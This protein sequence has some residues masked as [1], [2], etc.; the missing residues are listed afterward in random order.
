[1]KIEK[2]TIDRLAH[3]ARLNL[4]EEQTTK[5][6]N[7]LKVIL[8]WIEK[9]NELDTDDIEPLLSMSSELNNWRE[10]GDSNHLEREKALRNAPNHDEKF[11]KVPKVI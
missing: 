10:E 4:S 5:L 9:L 8:D 2:E 11:F 6:Q 3:L 7:D 1:M